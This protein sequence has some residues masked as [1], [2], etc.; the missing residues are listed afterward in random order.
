MSQRIRA[1]LA[2]LL[3]RA[4]EQRRRI[5][6]L[7]DSLDRLYARIGRVRARTEGDTEDRARGTTRKASSRKK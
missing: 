1:E 4:A 2:S 3:K 5:K 6:E 7:H